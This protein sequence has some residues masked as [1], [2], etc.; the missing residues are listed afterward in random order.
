MDIDEFKK[1]YKP[2]KVS[3]LSRYKKEIKKL[4]EDDFSQESICQF[5]RFKGIV[6]K[7]SNLSQ[8]L[9]RHLKGQATIKKERVEIEKVESEIQT[10]PAQSLFKKSEVKAYEIVEPDYSKYIH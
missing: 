5:L 10:P 4:L 7:Q 8:Y 6:T 2:K 3:N 9:K 1:K